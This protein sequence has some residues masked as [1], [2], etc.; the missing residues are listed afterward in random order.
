LIQRADGLGLAERQGSDVLE[1]V[2]LDLV[3]LRKMLG[4]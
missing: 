3:D 1:N 2:R 4:A